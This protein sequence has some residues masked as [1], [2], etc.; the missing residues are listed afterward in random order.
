MDAFP[1]P[2]AKLHATASPP[3]RD[4]G[5]GRTGQPSLNFVHVLWVHCDFDLMIFLE[6]KVKEQEDRSGRGRLPTCRTAAA[7]HFY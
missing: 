4:R 6:R 7:T 3:S 2:Q 1:D 5:R